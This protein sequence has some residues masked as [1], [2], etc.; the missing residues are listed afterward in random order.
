MVFS[1]FFIFRVAQFLTVFGIGFMAVF[2]SLYM[3]AYT[4]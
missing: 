4:G 1:A 3:T 2:G